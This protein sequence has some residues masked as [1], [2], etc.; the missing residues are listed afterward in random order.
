MSKY[1]W[2]EIDMQYRLTLSQG[3][4]LLDEV[5]VASFLKLFDNSY[6]SFSNDLLNMSDARQDC[7]V[8]FLD[9]KCWGGW[10]KTKG[11]TLSYFSEVIKREIYHSNF[12][13]N[14]GRGAAEYKFMPKF[15]SYDALFSGKDN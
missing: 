7:M 14:G 8:R 13:M 2:D 15:V 6:T 9:P 4:G 10:E 1:Y 5:I 11:T 12:I 3:K